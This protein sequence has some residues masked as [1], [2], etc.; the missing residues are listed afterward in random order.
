MNLGWFSHRHLLALFSLYF[1]GLQL[2]LRPSSREVR[3]LHPKIYDNGELFPCSFAKDDFRE[4][5]IPRNPN[6]PGTQIIQDRASDKKRPNL[7]RG[8]LQP[9]SLQEH[10]ASRLTHALHT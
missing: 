1:I 3:P 9:H 10:S 8:L 5:G 4:D 6:H 7:P 2:S